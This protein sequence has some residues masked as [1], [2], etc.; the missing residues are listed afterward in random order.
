MKASIL[1]ALLLALTVPQM[2]FADPVSNC[3]NGPNNTGADGTIYTQVVCSLYQGFGPSTIDLTPNLTYEGASIDVNNVG[4]GYIVVINGDPNTLS[5]DSNGLWNQSLWAAV[6]DF[7]SD[8]AQYG[9]YGSDSLE[10][11]WAGDSDF[12]SVSTVQTFDDNISDYYGGGVPAF[13]D[14]AFFVQY[15]YPETVLAY[16]TPAAGSSIEYD[17]YPTPEPS[18][19]LL[20]GTGLLGL[21]FVAFRKAKSSNRTLCS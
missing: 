6:L 8:P 14:S 21:A 11:Y 5:D 2:S 17:L 20:L 18:S 16:G 9:G 3:T 15:D 10:V 19:L 13:P 7:P 1:A 12:P 4:A